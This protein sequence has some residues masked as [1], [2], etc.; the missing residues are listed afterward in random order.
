[1]RVLLLGAGS[2]G[3]AFLR[4]LRDREAPFSLVGV[5]TAHH[6][7]LLMPE[8]GAAGEVLSHIETDGLPNLGPTGL[9]DILDE[10]KPDA[11]V[12]CIPQNIRSGD[13]ALGYMRLA[14]DRG[15]HVVTANKAPVALGY[16]DLASRA[17]EQG[18]H[19][20]FEA[21]IL[22]GLPVF[23]WMRSLGDRPVKAVR[24]VLNQTSSLVLEAVALGGSRARGLA[25]AQARGIAEAD[26]VLDLDGWDSAAKAALLANVWFDAALR[27]VDV[28]RAGCEDVKD[29][30]I[31]EAAE[32]GVQYRLVTT[33]ERGS[34]GKVRASV[35][36]QA[37]K[38]DDALHTPRGS[39]GTIHVTLEDGLAFTL[40]QSTSGLDDAAL[41]LLMD[42]EVARGLA[43]R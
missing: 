8:G 24:G 39:Q 36:P 13:P 14:L 23:R 22:D 34:D 31:R 4:G 5:V 35:D 42:L 1:M 29:A 18:V 40:R 28:V 16:R 25:R 10:A 6:G 27:V 15:L 43:D 26:S 17:K 32:E 11:I 20:G 41:A 21:T 2:L 33:V 7:R 3:R 19:L 30:K 38:P 9:P 37:L 12:E